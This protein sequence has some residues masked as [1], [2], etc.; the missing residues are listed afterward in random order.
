MTSV[1][2]LSDRLAK[3]IPVGC[4]I[5]SQDSTHRLDQSKKTSLPR[6]REWHHFRKL[7]GPQDTLLLRPDVQIAL[8][9][10]TRLSPLTKLVARR[11]IH[12][13]YRSDFDASNAIVRVYIL[14]D[15]VDNRL[16]P[17][18]DDAL[19]KARRQL[20][21]QLDYSSAAWEGNISA[22]TLPTS[23]IADDGPSLLEL[24]NTIPSPDPSTQDIT[25]PDYAGAI[26]S[27]MESN[28]YGLKTTLYP[29]QSRSVAVMLQREAETRRIMDPR[30]VE[31]LDHAGRKWYYDAIAG[32]ILREPRFYD[33]PRGGILAEEMGSGKTLMCLALCLATQHMPA[34]MPEKYW[35]A[36]PRTRKGAESLADMAAEVITKNGVAWKPRLE[37]WE[38]EIFYDGCIKAI[39]RNPGHYSIPRLPRRRATRFSRA[40]G[41]FQP[42]KVYLS[43]ASL[44][45]V[46]PNLVQQWEQEIQKHTI[47]LKVFV[48]AKDPGAIPPSAELLGYDLVLFSS[49]AFDQLAQKRHNMPDGTV[50]LDSHLARIHFKRCIV[51]EGHRLGSSASSRKLD[52]QA[53]LDCLHFTSGWIVTGTPSKGLF[54]VDER[55]NITEERPKEVGRKFSSQSSPDLEKDDLKRIGAIA[56]H[57]LKVRP[58][59]KAPGEAGETPADWALY[60]LQPKHSPRSVG[61]P[62]TLKATLESLIIRHRLSDISRLLPVVKEKIVFLEPCYQDTLVLNI[63]SMMIIFNSVQSQRTDQ[64]YFFHPGQRDALVQLVSNLSQSSFFGGSFFSVGELNKAIETA[65]KF[66]T[67]KKVTISTEDETLLRQ[68][69]SFG[70]LAVS[71]SLKTCAN[72]YHE[73]P[74]YVKDFPFA[75]SSASLVREWSLDGVA[76][77]NKGDN[78]PVL[79][80]AK[81]ISALQDIVKQHRRQFGHYDFDDEIRVQIAVSQLKHQGNLLRR[82]R[83]EA[84]DSSTRR[85]DQ[86]PQPALAGNTQLGEDKSNLSV[87]SNRPVADPEEET[88]K[89]DESSDGST[90][91]SSN[92]DGLLSVPEPFA[93]TQMISTASAKL[94]YLIDQIVQYHHD[95]QIL[96]F[97]DNDNIAY[98]LAEVLEVLGIQHLIYAKGIK[99]VRKA[100]YVASF[101]RENS[102]FRVMLMDINQ[103]AFGLNMQSA[104]RIYFISPVF[105][106]QVEAQ[107]VGRAKRIGQMAQSVTVETLVLR[108]SLEELIVKRRAEMTQHEQRKC[109]SIIDDKPI[110][111]WV[112]NAKILPLPGGDT[113]PSGP[114]QMAVLRAPQLIFGRGFGRETYHDDKD[115]E[116]I[117][118]QGPT[119]E[120]A[121]RGPSSPAS[122]SAQ[123]SDMTL[124]MTARPR[125]RSASPP[126]EEPISKRVRFAVE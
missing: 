68:A 64:D 41:R 62:E 67:E 53:V 29:Y 47:G 88:V 7:D 1:S 69:I 81:L 110:Y 11:W 22:D 8:L 60:V 49:T 104:S 38:D 23:Q 87:F 25:D 125:S 80:S 40:T 43:H 84:G 20:M 107:A 78:E 77:L 72:E 120:A 58:W 113:P 92:S 91:P 52:L 24:F 111:E 65:E 112:L 14:P 101:T 13:I 15:D 75:K 37:G 51:D 57:Y 115:L 44:I 19:H 119:V 114:E 108:G 89:K 71:N 99:R 126:S 73:V 39:Q 21:N 117:A 32:T 100:Q 83:S 66:L 10:S 34:R 2:H 18:T 102:R 16:V 97:Y 36:E 55:S 118:D 3:Y 85:P 17:R 70:R 28:V 56:T 86:R 4:L 45:V 54:G 124:T 106:R 5:L 96:V 30:L 93:E 116:G 46:P 98:Y 12:L 31:H 90:T 121:R 42:S 76:A 63:F 122:T 59:A 9:S 79:M 6:L 103:A 48:C 33:S 123:P 94:S 61:R 105:N 50:A 27:V 74:V 95:E 82:E 35:K 109:H 26:E